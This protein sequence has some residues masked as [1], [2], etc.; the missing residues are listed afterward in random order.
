M[1][2]V[3]EF[4]Y[5][6]F[7]LRSQGLGSEVYLN[8]IEDTAFNELNRMI[9]NN[10]LT[11]NMSARE[12]AKILHSV[13]GITCDEDEDEDGTTFQINLDPKCPNCGKHEMTCLDEVRPPVIIDIDIPRVEHKKWNT[14]ME[15]EKIDLF[16]KAL[17]AK[18]G[19]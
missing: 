17:K 8:A 6:E 14:F 5:G 10:D 9:K 12:R 2:L 3:S 4:T 16:H 11:K 18:C 1:S 7:I 19:F 15:E 13:Y